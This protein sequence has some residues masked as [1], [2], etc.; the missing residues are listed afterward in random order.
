MTLINTY[1]TCLKHI[2]ILT[3]NFHP[4][5]GQIRFHTAMWLGFA[6]R[7]KSAIDR[8]QKILEIMKIFC[9]ENNFED[10]ISL[11]NYCVKFST[12]DETAFIFQTDQGP[13]L[14]QL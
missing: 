9:E 7:K 2:S 10:P 4:H 1:L 14:T 5:F 3:L 8:E 6:P 13:N 12:Y 11:C